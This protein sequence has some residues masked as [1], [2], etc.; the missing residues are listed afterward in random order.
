MKTVRCCF[1]YLLAATSAWADFV[2]ERS[3][4]DS[5]ATNRALERFDALVGT[6]GYPQNYPAG[7]GYYTVDPRGISIGQVRY[8]GGIESYIL[9]PDVGDQFYSLDGTFAVALGRGAADIYFPG[10]VV[11]FG[12]DYGLSGHSVGT[13]IVTIY[14]SDGTTVSTSLSIAGRSQFLGFIGT[15]I[16]R[17]HLETD[18]AHY[19]LL[20]NVAFETTYRPVPDVS[21][22]CS[23]VE[24]CWWS[25]TN[26]RY[27]VQYQSDLTTGMWM[28][29]GA[30]ILGNGTT[31]CVTDTIVVGQ[32]GRFYR[33]V[34]L[35]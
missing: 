16:Q 20:D 23:Q 27:Q 33:T 35:P 26:K 28:D 10:G 21:I 8:G 31:N 22:R 12:T 32:P 7:S 18:N 15:E 14:L 2:T 11:A 3:A 29:L 19:I 25:I 34:E 9:G 5:I 13:L 4:F 17:I 24:V 30:P 1:F 6:P